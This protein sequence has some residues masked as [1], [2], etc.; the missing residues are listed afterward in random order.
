MEAIRAGIQACN[1]PASAESLFYN[2]YDLVEYF[3]RDANAKMVA[4]MNELA[5]KE[6]L[7]G[8]ALLLD[9]LKYRLKL[10]IPYAS[11]WEQALAQKGLPP[12]AKRAWKSLLDLASDAWFSI[13]DTS[14]DIKWYTKR[15]SIA[16]IYRSAEIYMLQ[17]K[18][19]DKINTMHFLER[20]LGDYETT[21]V[22]RPSMSQSLSD[23]AQ[24]ASGL[25]TVVCI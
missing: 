17:D 19:P 14:T 4:Y 11:T 13:G 10:V 5:T 16:T 24:V 9:G 12:N 25:F 1:Q 6:N 3:M 22:V 21:G 23:T 2:G 20:H 7:Q 8:T 18:S 15:L